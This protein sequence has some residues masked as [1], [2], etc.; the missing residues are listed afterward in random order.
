MAAQGLGL[1]FDENWAHYIAE[2]NKRVQIK[3]A[4]H[5]QEAKV[6]HDMILA[7]EKSGKEI[8]MPEGTYDSGHFAIYCRC[9]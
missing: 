9:T 2:A 4:T 3:R 8:V 5:L 1:C 6:Q 7:R